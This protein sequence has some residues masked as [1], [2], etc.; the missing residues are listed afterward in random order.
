MTMPRGL[1]EGIE[2]PVYDP[3]AKTAFVR[4]TTARALTPRARRRAEALITMEHLL[5]RH[6]RGYSLGPS[7]HLLGSLGQ[8]Y[9][10]S[11]RAI[12]LELRGRGPQAIVALAERIELGFWQGPHWGR[13]WHGRRRA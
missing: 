4:R 12:E 11:C 8:A 3:R 13:G 10:V 2:P 9:P 1:R 5:A 7:G 6:V